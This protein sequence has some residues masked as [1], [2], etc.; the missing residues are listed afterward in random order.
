MYVCMYVC[1]SAA[2]LSVCTYVCM[3]VCDTVRLFVCLYVCPSAC[4]YVCLSICMYVG[5]SMCLS[6]CMS[7]RPSAVRLSL[8]CLLCVS[9]VC[10]SGFSVVLSAFC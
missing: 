2:Y 4:L 5:M 8:L 6:V 3:Y 10:P 7:V 1:P 9:V